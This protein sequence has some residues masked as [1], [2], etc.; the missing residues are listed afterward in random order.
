M[1]VRRNTKIRVLRWIAL[2]LSIAVAPSVMTQERGQ[3]E[4]VVA[5]LHQMDARVL[6]IGVRLAEKGVPLC[7]SPGYATGFAVQLASQYAEP[8]RTAAVRLL[9][10]GSQ[11]TVSLVVDGSPADHAGLKIGDAIVAV[12]GA[13]LGGVQAS[14][15]SS[16]AD[17]E[18]ASAAVEAA[19]ADGR[20]ELDVVRQGR[21]LRIA[22]AGVPACRARFDV[23]AGGSNASANGTYVQ[24]ESNLVQSLPADADLAAIIAHEL[25][26]NILGHAKVLEGTRGGLFAG[27]G[28]SGKVMRA[29]EV[30]ADRL[31]M[32]LLALAGYSLDDALAFWT[33]F[34]RSHDFGVLSDR[35]HPGWRSRVAAMRA[36]ADRIAELRRT[37]APIRPDVSLLPETNADRPPA[38]PR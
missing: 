6:R 20:L 22:V 24:L 5:A 11:P 1:S 38:L 35:T 21:A 26:H 37:G 28:K 36:E 2:T 27:F 16:F 10:V 25:A 12:D 3:A 30:A 14:Q 18:A 4:A 9:N 19:L 17:T 32:Y 34:G 31:S 8:Y 7:K 33:R 23:R 13:S 29:T 15:G